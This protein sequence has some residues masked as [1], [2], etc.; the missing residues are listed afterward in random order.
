MELLAK[1]CVVLTI[2]SI[3]V[4]VGI[5]KDKGTLDVIYYTLQQRIPNKNILM[6]LLSTIYG[7]L[8]IPGRVSIATGMFDT[9]TCKK[10][11][12]SELG[13]LAYLSTHHY[14]LWSPMEK[15]VLI[16]LA[17]TGISYIDFICSMGI[18]I[19]IFLIV[20][21][22]YVVFVVKDLDAIITD[23]P[24]VDIKL[25]SATDSLILLG[26]VVACCM[27]MFSIL[28]F[29]PIY[30]LYMVVRHRPSLSTILKSIDFKLLLT[31]AVV[32]LVSYIIQQHTA[33]IQAHAYKLSTLYGLHVAIFVSFFAALLL[34]SSSRFAAITVIMTSMFGI[35]YLPL[36]YI[37][38]FCG[39]LL[40]PFHKCVSIS[41]L[42][43]NTKFV[44]FYKAV[45]IITL[46]LLTTSIINFF[47]I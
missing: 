7:I 20:T 38:D 30:A 6:C 47:I 44:A 41:N 13:V 19:G 29:F 17:G 8:P 39:Y 37:V 22:Y 23:F 15:S 35:A 9:W 46:I 1:E 16:V 25:G 24:P 21:Y 34:G 10:Q 27:Q 5:F 26:G 32:V 31:V 40:S 43:F 2:M 33:E 45:G 28:Y 14:Y 11:D 18:Y 36:F 12:R 4:C 3:M 42:Y